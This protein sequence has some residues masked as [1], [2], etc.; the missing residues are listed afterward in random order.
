MLPIAAVAHAVEIDYWQYS[1]KSRVDAMDRLIAA[2]E[3]ENPD[4]KVHQTT[5]PYAQYRTKVAAAVS[6]GE[7]PDV[8][9]LYYGWLDDY[10]NAGILK[11]LSEENF[12]AAEI[13]KD[14]FPIVHNMKADG[15]YFALPTAVRSLGLFWNKK[16]FREAGLDPDIPPKTLDELAD[17]AKKLTKHDR[18]GNIIQVGITIGPIDQDHNWWREVL[19]R[20]FG[21]TPY[22]ADNTKVT[23]DDEAGIQAFDYYAGLVTDHKVSVVDFMDKGEIAFKAGRAA[24]HID[25]SF[26]LSTF[27]RAR[28]LDYGV[29]ELPTYDGIKSNFA[30]YWVNGITSKATGEKREAAEK[31]LKFITSEKAMQLWLDQV[32]ELPARRAV[33]NRPENRD[34][35]KFGPFIRGLDYAHSTKFYSEAEQR[36][37]VVDM[38]DRVVLNGMSVARSLRI[39]AEED[40]AII[41]KAR[42][43]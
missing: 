28:R 38:L 5:F 23:Y 14:F 34:N 4:I 24:I 2:F 1:Y 25:G 11:P 12:P 30:S 37:T 15:Q 40:Q 35:P 17:F 42:M 10:L 26:A 7:G 8:V 36:R 22:N 21:G 19:V 13:E 27:D 16:L 18:A 29:A 33:A 41:D 31:F 32:G 9:Q 43:K 20:Q 6:A 3:A 39:A